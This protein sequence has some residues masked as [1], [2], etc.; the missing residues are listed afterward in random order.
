VAVVA[1]GPAAA[2]GAVA[3]AAPGAAAGP[4]AAAAVVT[5][6]VET[7]AAPQAS[8]AATASDGVAAAE[9]GSYFAP[10]LRC[11]LALGGRLPHKGSVATV[12]PLRPV[13]L[14]VPA[15]PRACFLRLLPFTG[16]CRGSVA[17]LAGAWIGVPRAVRQGTRDP[18]AA[19]GVTPHLLDHQTAAV[20]GRQ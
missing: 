17:G 9:L 4:E 13:L 7:A 10:R 3:V 16:G 11:P 19:V 20:E 5:G 12:E 2:T 14:A 15:A 1:V 18:D 8:P 6:V